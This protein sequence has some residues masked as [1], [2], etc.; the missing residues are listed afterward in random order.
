MDKKRNKMERYKMVKINQISKSEFNI[1]ETKKDLIY[2]YEQ[3]INKFGPFKMLV[4]CEIDENQYRIIDGNKVFNEYLKNGHEKVLVYN[5]GKLSYEYEIG[6][7]ILLNYNFDRLDYIGIAEAINKI[8]TNQAEINVAS[9]ITGISI[10][11]VERYKT[12][13]EFDWNEFVNQRIETNQIDIFNLIN[14]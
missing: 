2:K 8:C 12:L 3:F 1:T 6:Y 10:T 9:N 11:D 13:L 7:R 4:V 5:L 14:D